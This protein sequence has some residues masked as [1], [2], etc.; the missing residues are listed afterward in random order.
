METTEL[1][2]ELSLFITIYCCAAA[3]GYVLLMVGE[4]VPKVQKQAQSL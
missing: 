2:E 4:R 1:T 3:A